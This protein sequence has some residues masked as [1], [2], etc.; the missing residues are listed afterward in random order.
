MTELLRA[1]I[2][3][4]LHLDRHLHAVI[5]DAAVDVPRIRSWL[6]RRRDALPGYVR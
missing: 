6:P 2:D 3:L 5:Q 4:L 1:G